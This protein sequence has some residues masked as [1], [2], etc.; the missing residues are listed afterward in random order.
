MEHTQCA[1]FFLTR[2]YR[3]LQSQSSLKSDNHISLNVSDQLLNTVSTCL[4]FS[5]GDHNCLR[6]FQLMRNK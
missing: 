4:Q 1:F 6:F 2:K 5:K 3:L